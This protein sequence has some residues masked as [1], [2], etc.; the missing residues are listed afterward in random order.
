MKL[1][2]RDIQHRL[3]SLLDS[4]EECPASSLK[5]LGH[6]LIV[7]NVMTAKSIL[8]I[9]TICIPDKFP[10]ASTLVQ[11]S[12]PSLNVNEFCDNEDLFEKNI[13][14][15]GNQYSNYCLTIPIKN[16]NNNNFEVPINSLIYTNSNHTHTLYSNITGNN[17]NHHPITIDA[18]VYPLWLRG[19][20]SLKS[21]IK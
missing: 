18:F 8:K 2:F 7:R 9:D 6:P 12:F 14:A 4:E 10:S 13:P 11:D 3:Q 16:D 17:H 21:Q 15:V 20:W 1:I 19:F 5:L